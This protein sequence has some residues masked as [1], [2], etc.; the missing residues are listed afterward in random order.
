MT[1]FKEYCKFGFMHRQCRCPGGERTIIGCTNPTHI[2]VHR[3]GVEW[4]RFYGITVL[5]PDGW[6]H[7][8]NV[9]MYTPIT[10][11]DF[12]NRAAESTVN[13]LDSKLFVV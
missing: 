13:L 11:S 10:L 7:K 2:E 6:R 8:D 9:D 12:K 5:D 1:H 3:S 4:A